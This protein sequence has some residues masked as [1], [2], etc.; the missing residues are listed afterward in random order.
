MKSPPVFHH[1]GATNKPRSL[2]SPEKTD[3]ARGPWPEEARR[4]SECACLKDLG[5]ASSVAPWPGGR[6]DQGSGDA[7]AIGDART[8]ISGWIQADGK[9]DTNGLLVLVGMSAG[10]DRG[11]SGGIKLKPVAHREVREGP[12]AAAIDVGGVRV[13]QGASL[14]V[15]E[16]FVDCHEMEVGWL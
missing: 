7:D 15:H 3:S 1:R 11:D 16:V 8:F 14:P 12:A 9:V 5:S 10:S 6:S 13:D 4:G 2:L